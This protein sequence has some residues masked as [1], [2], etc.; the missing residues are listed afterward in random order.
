MNQA[1][2]ISKGNPNSMNGAR[3]NRMALESMTTTLIGTTN[4]TITE[5]VLKKLWEQRNNRFSHEYT[6]EAKQ[7]EQTLGMITCYPVRLLNQLAIPTIMQIIKIRGI[8]LIPYF[9][10]HVAEVWNLIHLNEGQEDEYHIGTIATDQ[11]SRGL[12][13]G[14]KLLLHADNMARKSGFHKI[15]L[16]VKEHNV[17]ARKLYERVGYKVVDKIDKKPFHL[18]RMVK[19]LS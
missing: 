18:Y 2:S 6:Y 12:G 16:T 19:N 7:G 17:L 4:E 11:N 14:T 10:T 9:A 13:I 8:S 15:S 5:Q 3:L 1:I